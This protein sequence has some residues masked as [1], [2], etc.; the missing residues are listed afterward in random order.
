VNAIRGKCSFRFH[1]NGNLVQVIDLHRY[2]L[3][4]D[5]GRTSVSVMADF[6]CENPNGKDQAFLTI[7]FLTERGANLQTFTL[8]K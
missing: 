2:S 6:A 1:R 4:L 8:S 7:A 3:F 5:Y